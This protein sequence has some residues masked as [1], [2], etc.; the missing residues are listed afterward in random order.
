MENNRI[1]LELGLD[2]SAIT[3]ALVQIKSQF[4]GTENEFKRISKNISKAFNE[5]EAA[6]ALYGKGSSQVVAANKKL[7]KSFIELGANGIDYASNS[8]NTLQTE[9]KKIGGTLDSSNNS[10]KKNNQ[11]WTNLALVIQDLPFGFRGI[12]NN[13]PALIGGIA[14]VGGAAYVAFSAI[15]AIYTAFGKQIDDAIFRTTSFE[16]AQKELNKTTLESAKSTETARTELFK[17]TSI[18]NSAK[19]GFISKTEALALYNESLG[20]SFGKVNSLE[21]AEQKLVDKAPK[22]I[23]ALM[24]KAKAEYYF[25][26]ASEYAVKKDIAGLE[27]QTSAL[28]KLLILSKTI[29]RAGAAVGVKGIIKTLVSGITSAQESGVA[30]VKETAGMISDVLK[31]EGEKSMSEYYSVLKSAGLKDKDIEQII[32]K[33]NA[34]LLNQTLKDQKEKEDAIKAANANEIKSYID[35]LTGRDKEEYEAGMKLVKD[36]ELMKAAGFQDSTTYYTSYRANML[37]IAIKYDNKELEEARKKEE[38]IGKI[39]ED[40]RSDIKNAIGKINDDFA[41]NEI[42]NRNAE[43]S[44]TLKATKGNYEAQKA[45]ILSAIED[46]ERFKQSA[47]DAGGGA[48]L[49]DENIKNLKANLEGLIDPIEQFELDFNNVI[50]NLISGVLV[51]FGTQ[52]G[53]MF[54]GEGFSMEGFLNMIADAMIK[55][56]TYLV[57][58]SKLFIAVKTLFAS[59]GALA[60]FMIPIGLAAIATGVALKSSLSKTKKFANGGIVSGPTMGLMGEYPGAQNN[61]EVVAPL[62]KLKDMIGGGGGGGTFVLRGQD[63]LVALNRTQKSSSLKGQNISLA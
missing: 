43:L 9:A 28:D 50:N 19:E 48:A 37:E 58:M 12:Q 51:E 11:Q 54:S 2:F 14:G 13:L 15:I 18:I 61:P 26:K 29:G 8:F 60:P 24:L 55:L 52:L 41:K 5:A 31:M 21:E 45:A 46:N 23:E 42:K 62:D 38:K 40:N 25:A 35:S 59:G 6:A 36:L 20:D 16:K 27:D 32:K 49:F 17:I 4:T 3:E 30:K 39:I 7:E 22:Y 63:L 56:G 47:I 10:I 34:K 33:L 1:S 53:K 57:S 44:A